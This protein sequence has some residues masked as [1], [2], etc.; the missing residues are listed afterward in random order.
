MAL[1]D[2]IEI[3]RDYATTYLTLHG[4]S[5]VR[6]DELKEIWSSPSDARVIL[7]L[8][9]LDDYQ[10]LMATVVAR[11]AQEEARA[12]DDVLIDL[13]WPAYDKLIARTKADRSSPAVPI[14]EALNLNDA[15][16]DLIVAAARAAERPAR[17]YAGGW[18]AS[19]GEYF[20]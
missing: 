11:V 15:L 16:R 6:Q 7:P 17:T 14:Q 5:R 3:D 19:V 9:R 4:W 1:S 8:Q 2:D 18:S 10:A 12:E 13:A 20:D